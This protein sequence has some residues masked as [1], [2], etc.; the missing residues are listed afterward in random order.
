M[1]KLYRRSEPSGAQARA[2][3]LGAPPPESPVE[4]G[5]ALRAARERAGISLEEA[6][7]ATS[8]PK[9]DLEA[10]EHGRLEL[11]HVEQAAVV[12][13]W[14]YAELVGLE[15]APLVETVRRHW[16]RP[17][18]AADALHAAPGGPG[19]PRAHLALAEELLRKI[20]PRAGELASASPLGLSETTRQQLSERSASALHALGAL[21]PA[22]GVQRGRSRRPSRRLA[23]PGS[24]AKGEETATSGTPGPAEPVEAPAAGVPGPPEPGGAG[25]GPA[26]APRGATGPVAPVEPPCSDTPGAEA[27]RADEGRPRRWSS[28]LARSFALR[29]GFEVEAGADA[30]A[31]AE[32]DP[33][34][35]AG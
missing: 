26:P 27:A 5:L 4:V 28:Q 24:G 33:S 18:L 21:G 34:R 13:L 12:G 6:R 29:F 22:P 1:P 14:R 19:T 16:P 15:P 2:H 3:G 11:L 23:A 7:E 25:P 10:L 8:V 20:A 35:G 32:Q 31:S 17:A 30:A 9:V